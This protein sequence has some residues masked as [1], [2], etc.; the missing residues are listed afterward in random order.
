MAA[1]FLQLNR[2]KTEILVVGAKA[3]RQLVCKYLESRSLKT[4][5]QIKNLGETMD[6]EVSLRIISTASPR[7][8]FSNSE[9]FP[10]SEAFFL[11][12]PQRNS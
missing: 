8:P 6:G 5:E 4:S 1:N 2:A 9:T 12:V 7:L 11:S 3:Q 10:K